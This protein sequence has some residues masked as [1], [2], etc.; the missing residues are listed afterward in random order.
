MASIPDQIK[1]VT[2]V[3]VGPFICDGVVEILRREAG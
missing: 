3:K 2:R 1:E